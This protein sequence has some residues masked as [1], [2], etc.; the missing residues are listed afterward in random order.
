[1]KSAPMH[2][3]TAAHQEVGSASPPGGGGSVACRVRTVECHTVV[4]RGELHH[5]FLVILFDIESEL[6]S[7]QDMLVWLMIIVW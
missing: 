2:A 6:P 3:G 5:D 4:L 7:V 1:M